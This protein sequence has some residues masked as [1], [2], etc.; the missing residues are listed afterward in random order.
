MPQ[1]SECQRGGRGK[2]APYETTHSLI[3]A[4]L[5]N[6]I[7][8]LIDSYQKYVE[9]GGDPDNPPR[10]CNE[11]DTTRDETAVEV[12]QKLQLLDARIN[13]KDKGYVTNSFS[14]GLKL[15]KEIFDLLKPVNR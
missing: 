7:A 12:I 13:S 6:Q 9:Q 4:P 2:K 11:Q 14:Q 3:P 8:E 1:S 10:F 5:K 15:L